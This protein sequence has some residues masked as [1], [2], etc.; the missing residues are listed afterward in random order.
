MERIRRDIKKLR[1]E[2]PERPNQIQWGAKKFLKLYAKGCAKWVSVPRK[3][4]EKEAYRQ[5]LRDFGSK[6]NKNM[7]TSTLYY[8][9]WQIS[10]LGEEAETE[11]WCIASTIAPN[12]VI[13]LWTDYRD[14]KTKY[15]T[16]LKEKDHTPEYEK[17]MKDLEATEEMVKFWEEELASTNKEK[18]E[19]PARQ[20]FEHPPARTVKA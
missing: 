10:F 14:D 6:I 9:I 19:D 8:L 13:Q 17:E 2:I 15:C 20:G 4:S 5:A 1:A 16:Y 3:I 7:T 11:A 12:T 18:D